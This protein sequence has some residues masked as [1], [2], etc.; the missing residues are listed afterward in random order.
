M[1]SVHIFSPGSGDGAGRPCAVSL[2]DVPARAVD[3]LHPIIR[4]DTLDGA[5]P[6][7]CTPRYR[8]GKWKKSGQQRAPRAVLSRRT[9]LV[10]VSGGDVSGF[11]ALVAVLLYRACG[12]GVPAIAETGASSRTQIPPLSSGWKQRPR[13]VGTR[14]RGGRARVSPDSETTSPH[15]LTGGWAGRRRA[16][17][18]GDMRPRRLPTGVAATS[19]VPAP[20]LR[21]S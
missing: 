2:R 15:G 14:Y 11:A 8:Q 17:P 9:A 16:V 20:T 4:P 10:P 5:I 18:G 21:D 7:A 13:L 6:P 1:Y 12:R 3:L 19:I